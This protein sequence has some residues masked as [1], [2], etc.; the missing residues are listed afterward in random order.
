MK[1]KKIYFSLLLTVFLLSGCQSKISITDVGA[2]IDAKLAQCEIGEKSPDEAWGHVESG[3]YLTKDIESN[4]Q[5]DQGLSE[6][7]SAEVKILV[8]E[9]SSPSGDWYR[10]DHYCFNTNNSILKLSS[11]LRTFYGGV[12]VVRTWIYNENKKPFTQEIMITNLDSGE[13]IPENEANYSDNPPLLVKSYEEL[14]KEIGLT[15]D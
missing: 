14:L 2:R 5:V 13:I 12:K 9:N 8:L 10:V 7:L 6:W 1:D 15:R 4:A 11:D 3:W